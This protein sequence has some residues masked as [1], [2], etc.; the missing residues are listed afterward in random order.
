MLET[1]LL[2]FAYYLFVYSIVVATILIIWNDTNAFVEYA[3][4]LG[5]EMKTY[6]SDEGL[7]ISYPDHLQVKYNNFITTLLSCP[8]C[9]ACWLNIGAYFIHEF[10][11]VA[12]CGVYISLIFYFLFKII[13]KKSDG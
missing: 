9:L 7:G 12:I 1:Q 3:R 4:L 11:F 8:I 13:M 5:F 10:K 6:E 2:T